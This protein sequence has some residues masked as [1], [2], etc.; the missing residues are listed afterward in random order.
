MPHVLP[1]CKCLDNF[2]YTCF[3]EYDVPNTKN[4]ADVNSV[5]SK[6]DIVIQVT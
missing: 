4:Y 5:N 3:F 6:V 2:G 1:L